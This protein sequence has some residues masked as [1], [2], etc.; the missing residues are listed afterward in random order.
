MPRKCWL[1]CPA[2]S[3]ETCVPS[4]FLSPSSTPVL[5]KQVRILQPH[6]GFGSVPAGDYWDEYFMALIDSC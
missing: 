5:Y 2:A 4:T 1:R 3:C 6:Q